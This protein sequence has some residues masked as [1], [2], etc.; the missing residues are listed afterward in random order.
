MESDPTFADLRGVTE[1]TPE[2]SATTHAKPLKMLMTLNLQQL[3][4]AALV[5]PGRT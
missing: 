3:E 1:E 5:A 4:D 2:G